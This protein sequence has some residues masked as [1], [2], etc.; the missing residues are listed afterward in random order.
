MAV[1]VTESGLK[2]STA[3]KSPYILVVEDERGAEVEKRS[4]SL[5]TLRAALRRAGGAHKTHGAKTTVV[6]YEIVVLNPEEVKHTYRG[7]YEVAS[8]RKVG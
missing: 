4:A 2:V 1:I 3:T 8:G 5:E 7:I 6:N